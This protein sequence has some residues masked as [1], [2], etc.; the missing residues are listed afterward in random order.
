MSSWWVLDMCLMRAWCILD[1]C[2]MNARCMLAACLM[3]AC[4]N[5]PKVFNAS[6]FRDF[7]ILHSVLKRFSLLVTAVI[8][9]CSVIKS[10]K[11]NEIKSLVKFRIKISLII[12]VL[13]FTWFT[14]R[15]C[16]QLSEVYKARSQW[17]LKLCESDCKQLV[18]EWKHLISMISF[19][20][21]NLCKSWICCRMSYMSLRKS[22]FYD[23]QKFL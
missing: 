22:L 10:V 16:F 7:I 2:L 14:I 11:K 4:L 5:F 1:T 20:C 12:H 8:S 13:L 3:P 18:T 6:N 9:L 23:E 21:H 15:L 19:V 17:K